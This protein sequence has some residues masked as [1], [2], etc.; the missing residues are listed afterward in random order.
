MPKLFHFHLFRLNSPTRRKLPQKGVDDIDSVV[1]TR[2][3]YSMP[4]VA[5]QSVSLKPTRT[6]PS[7][8]RIGRFTIM[9]SDASKLYC[10]SSLMVGSL[11]FSFSSLYNCPLVLKNFFSGKP[12]FLCQSFNSSTVGLFFWICLSSKVTLLASSHFLAFWQVVH[13]G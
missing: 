3:S 8:I 7:P 6:K 2:I 5:F 1:I 13:L 9:P 11:S 10:S 4:S 12:L